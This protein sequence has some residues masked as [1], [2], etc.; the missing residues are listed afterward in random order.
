MNQTH[1]EVVRNDPY[2]QIHKYESS[3]KHNLKKE[4]WGHQVEE[5][6][7]R[8]FGIFHSLRHDVEAIFGE[9][10]FNNFFSPQGR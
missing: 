6:C 1:D 2:I 3:R 10:P 7:A 9:E 4:S 8:L 5:H